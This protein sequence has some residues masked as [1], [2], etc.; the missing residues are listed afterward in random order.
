MTVIL[1][2]IQSGSE[3]KA[4]FIGIVPDELALSPAW[5][6]EVAR[7]VFRSGQSI[8]ATIGATKESPIT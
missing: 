5:A 1:G 7:F 2:R 6:C 8:G 4:L 3:V